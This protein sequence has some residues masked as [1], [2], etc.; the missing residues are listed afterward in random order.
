MGRGTH[1]LNFV[2]NKI[3]ENVSFWLDP[4]GP[5]DQDYAQRATPL[6]CSAVR[7]ANSLRSDSGALGRFTPQ[8]RLTPVDR[9]RSGLHSFSEV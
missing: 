6:L 9:G 3:K 8:L 4:K 2:F 5:K 1:N 7:T